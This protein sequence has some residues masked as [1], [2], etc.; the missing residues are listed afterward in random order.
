MQLARRRGAP[1]PA[2]DGRGHRR[3]GDR[4]SA[5]RT[6]PAAPLRSHLETPAGTLLQ[7]PAF[8]DAGVGVKL[9]TLTPGNA[10]RGLPF[11][12]A[13]YVLFDPETQ[14]PDAIVDGAA[15]TALRTA[16]VSGLATRHL[17]AHRRPAP[18]DLRRRRPGAIAPRG[19]ARRPPDRTCHGR[20]AD[21]WA[22]AGAGGEA[23]GPGSTRPSAEPNDVA[24]A[25][26]IC[27]CTTSDARCSTARLLARGRTSTPSAATDPTARELDTVA[28]ARAQG[29]RRD[30]RGGVRR[31]RRTAA[32][33]SRRAR[34]AAITW[35]P[36]SRRSCTAPRCARLRTTSRSSSP[37]GWR[38][39]I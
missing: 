38:S 18:R 37:W 12:N 25:D 15:L 26:I 30:A 7:M 13:V 10:E 3:P 6:R 22:R 2:P 32:S 21:A 19:D 31:G 23:R 14:V 33:R 1:S 28:V 29:G 34:S 35:S 9:V 20:V 24:D 17:A 39:R 11:I 36:T 4:R 16:A 27:T 5:S 8:G